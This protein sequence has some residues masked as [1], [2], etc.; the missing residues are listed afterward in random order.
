[1]QQ[2]CTNP[3][4]AVRNQNNTL[5]TIP[6]RF[7][8]LR[9]PSAT[10]FDMALNKTFAFTERLRFQFRLEAFNAFNTP[11]FGNPDTN[12]TGNS[13]GVLNPN[14]GQRNIP[15]QVQLGFKFNF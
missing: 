13:F 1:V 7:G 5:R 11:L 3:A 14:N 6:L 9:Q 10:T 8:N 12:A 2:P 4:F 15:R